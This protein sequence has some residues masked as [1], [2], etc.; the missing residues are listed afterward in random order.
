MLLMGSWNIHVPNEFLNDVSFYSTLYEFLND[1]VEWLQDNNIK[2]RLTETK[3]LNHATYSTIY[4]I[5]LYVEKSKA[6][7]FKLRWA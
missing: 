4:D 5:D 6:T 7:F 3:K 2:F 1:K